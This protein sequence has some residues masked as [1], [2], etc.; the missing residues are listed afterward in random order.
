MSMQTP[1][2]VR[3]RFSGQVTVRA[4]PSF[5]ARAE[6]HLNRGVP[7]Y[8]GMPPTKRLTQTGWRRK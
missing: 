4:T 3:R 8:Q 2:T 1:I 5:A 7:A 6:R